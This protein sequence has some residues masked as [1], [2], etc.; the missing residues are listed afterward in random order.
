[1]KL[2]IRSLTGQVLEIEVANEKGTVAELKAQIE[3]QE[4]I[5]AIFQR[6]V[7]NGNELDDDIALSTVEIAEDAHINIVI[8]Q[9]KPLSPSVAGPRNVEA[10]DVAINIGSNNVPDL[11]AGEVETIVRIFLWATTYPVLI[12]ALL[13]PIAGFVGAKRYHAILIGSYL[14]YLAMNVGFRIYVGF[15]LSIRGPAVYLSAIGIMLEL[16]IGSTVLRFFRMV[17]DVSDATRSSLVQLE[18][19]PLV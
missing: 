13:L 14:C 19:F 6:L 10:N 1:M 11:Q 12:F 2:R 3:L 9:L 5:P 15:L 7:F 18:K 17:S 8:R 4:G 16:F